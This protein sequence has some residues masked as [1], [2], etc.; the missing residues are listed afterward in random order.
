[1]TA[2]RDNVRPALVPELNATSLEASLRFWCDILGFRVLYGRPDEG[3]AAIER[4][5]VE[6]M[7][8][9]HDLGPGERVGIWETAPRERPFGRGINFEITVTN[10]DA[11]LSSILAAGWPIFFGPEERWYRVGEEEAGVRQFL[12]QDPDGYLLRFSQ[13]IGRRSA[14]PA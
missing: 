9:Q 12:V 7:I 5:G 13:A 14:A 2:V 11:L 10:A 4:D 8:D 1:M 3:F 6:F